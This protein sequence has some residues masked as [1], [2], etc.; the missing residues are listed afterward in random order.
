MQVNASKCGVMDVG[1]ST[2]MLFTMQHDVVPQVEQYKY[3]GLMFNNSWVEQYKYLG[4]MV[5]NSWVEQYKYLGLMVNNSWNHNRK[6][7]LV[8]RAMLIRSVLLPMATYGGELFGMSMA[9]STKLQSIIDNACRA[10]MGCGSSTALSRLRDELKIATVNTKTA[11]AP[12]MKSRLSTWVS[13]TT[14]WVKRYCQDK[15]PG[16]TAKAL[17]LRARKNDKSKITAWIDQIMAGRIRS[18]GL[19]ELVYPEYSQSIQSITKIRSGCLNTILKLARAK[20][21]DS[22]YLDHCPC[23]NMKVAE[24]IEHIIFECSQPATQ[25]LS[26]IGAQS[27]NVNL[28]VVSMTCTWIIGISL[29]EFFI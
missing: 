9:R 29:R 28:L 1:A 14:K 7:P 5:N 27:L 23:C 18:V 3:L 6:V 16:Q 25:R 8:L 13:G 10:V 20:I 12:P 2:N 11:V 17:A 26:T 21:A 15:V 22:K 19:L 24:S 4:L